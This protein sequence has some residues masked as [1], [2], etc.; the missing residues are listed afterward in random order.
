[1]ERFGHRLPDELHNLLFSVRVRVLAKA[2]GVESVTKRGDRVTLKLVDEVGGA[3]IALER[4]LGHGTTVGNQQL[5]VP[6]AQPE[7][8][9]GQALL[10]VLRT[11][12]EF[13]ERAGELS[14]ILA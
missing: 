1:M 6:L 10:E 13:R 4:V 3:R 7:I 8:P 14:A 2:A 5:H 11:L 12:A 9:W